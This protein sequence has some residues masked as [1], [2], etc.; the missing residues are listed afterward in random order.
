VWLTHIKGFKFGLRKHKRRILRCLSE[1]YADE[2]NYIKEHHCYTQLSLEVTVIHYESLEDLIEFIETVEEPESLQF[3]NIFVDYDL[4]SLDSSLVNEL[5]C[6][7]R[8][9][10]INIV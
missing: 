8:K 2:L 6:I 7:L 4:F 3:K 5:Y 10:Q 9:I 1:P